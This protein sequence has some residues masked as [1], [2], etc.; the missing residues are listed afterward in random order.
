MANVEKLLHG[1][2][3]GV[4]LLKKLDLLPN[5]E[6]VLKTAKAK[7]RDHLKKVIGEAT[8]SRLGRT[9][10]PRFFTQ[11]SDKY[12][13]LNRPAWLPPQ[14]MDL[15]DGVYLPLTFMKNAKPS[16][17]AS[18]FF[19]IVDAAL[20]ELITREGWKGFEAKPTCARVIIDDTAHI[21]V[22][23]YAIPDEEFTK[24]TKATLDAMMAA[25]SFDFMQS[26]IDRLDSWDVL[27]SDKV[28]LAHREEDWKA[29]DPRQVHEWF[30]DGIEDYGER[31]RRECR[32]LKAW[33][34]HHRLNH[35]S[36]IILMVC[37]WTVFEEV[38]QLHIPK[39]DDLMLVKIAERLRDL[40]AQ[41]I[42]NP[43]D[44]DEMLG[45]K[46]TAEERTAAIKAAAAIHEEINMAVHHCYLPEVA[47]KH[48]QT[49]FGARIPERTD[50]VSVKS[51]AAATVAAAPVVYVPAPEVG[52]SKSG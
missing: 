23:L 21:D 37:A 29:S 39:R 5:E 48:M 47:V 15:D 20:Q 7:V 43:T 30:L 52:R 14:R 38:G 41:P 42:P 36:S 31:L 4:D 17:A 1:S 33:R 26:R 16:E 49:I 22:P 28:L 8:K 10:T 13:T 51:A 24:L 19:A 44:P 6:K 3:D 46:W 12:K 27:P 50:L 9:I 11:G 32:Y 40:Y 25:D 45:A 35:I 2:S 34:D 18:I